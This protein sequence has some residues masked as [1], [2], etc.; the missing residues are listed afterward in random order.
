MAYT[1]ILIIEDEDTLRRSIARGMEM[2]G[3]AVHES[4]S[5]SSA[6][7][8]V[9]ET[10]F[11][12]ILT[13]VNLPDGSGI[14]L[15]KQL[16]EEGYVGGIVVMTAYGTIDTAVEAMKSGAD[17]FLQKPVRLDELSIVL[18]KVLAHRKAATRLDTYERLERIHENASG[19]LGE[20]EA[21]SRTI[22]LADRYAR[23]PIP[24]EQSAGDDLPTILLLGETGS[25]KGVIA[26]HIHDAGVSGEAKDTPPFVHVNCAALPANLIEGELFGNEKG[27]YTDAKGARP[28]LFET[29]EG[30]TIFLD[31]IGEMPTEMQ[32]KLLLVVENGTFRRLGGTRDRR[33][34]TRIIAATNQDLDRRV[35]TGEFRSDLLYRLNAL[36]I[37]IPPLRERGEDALRIAER[38][39]DQMG[40]DLGRPGLHLDES[41]KSSI[42]DHSWPGNVRELINCLKR[43]SI[44][45]DDEAIT[46]ETLGLEI[47]SPGKARQLS[48]VS[49]ESMRFNFER[50]P[51]SFEDLE[52]ALIVSALEY[53]NGNVS[54]AAR[55]IG[56]NRGALRYRIERLGLEHVTEEVKS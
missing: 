24:T 9:N 48:S 11:G 38:L 26:R 16:R 4:D 23:L 47:D 15:V 31:E 45:A 35:E 42:L 21:F 2:D 18:E 28:G 41:A 10:E 39:I 19:P 54:K 36:T 3:Y 37:R 22:G 14:D 33:V 13:D 50:G 46:S 44:L 32:A 51:I 40:H 5:L 30:G 6:R 25:G 27:A 1:E 53:A 20:S 7:R 56:L 55:C 52:R 12:V 17:D 43:A 29:A 34:R 49:A 8:L